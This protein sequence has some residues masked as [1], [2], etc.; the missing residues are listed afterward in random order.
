MTFLKNNLANILTLGRMAMLPLII[1]LFYLEAAW[2]G[3]AMLL[4]FILYIIAAASDYFDGV[5]AR[6]YN[7]ITAFGTF[8]DPISDKIFVATILL[9]LVAF[10]KVNDGWVILVVLI[11]MREFLVSGLREY[12]GPKN[13]KMP[14]S[15]LAKWKTFAQMFAIG[16]LI[17]AGHAPYAR[18]IGL[19]LLAAATL[20]TL[21]TGGQY[22]WK[23]LRAMKE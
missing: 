9:M 7:Q 18:E 10:D 13:I 2:G 20:L 22:L 5:I 15:V 16:F 11:F 4:C 6:K 12:L 17:V 14:V 23:G 21:I 8:L 19:Y 1:G 3:W